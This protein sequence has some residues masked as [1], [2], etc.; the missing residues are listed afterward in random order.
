MKVNFDFYT[1]EDIYC[2]GDV[3]KDVIQYLKEQGEENYQEIFEKDMRWPV[4]YHITPIRKNIVNWYPFQEN[5]EVLEIGAG[6]GAITGILCDK[7]KHVTSVE[8]SKQR[9]SAIG[10]LLRFR[11]CC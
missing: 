11:Y 9:A 3:E 7:A 8:L 1:G 5:S 10:A 4:F 2:D 6:M